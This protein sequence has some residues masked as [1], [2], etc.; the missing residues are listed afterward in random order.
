MKPAINLQVGVLAHD[1]DVIGLIVDQCLS[2]VQPLDG[3]QRL[4]LYVTRY[5]TTLSSPNVYLCY[6]VSRKP[7]SDCTRRTHSVI[8]ASMLLL[9]THCLL[10]VDHEIRG[11]SKDY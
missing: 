9:I 2:V 7:W 11:H 5:V 3:R 8:L 4:G 6:V 10:Y 1:V